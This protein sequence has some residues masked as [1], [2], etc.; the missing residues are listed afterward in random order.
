M[1]LKIVLGLIAV[2]FLISFL[3]SFPAMLLWN[4]CLVPA[5]PALAEVGWLQMWGI[6]ILAGLMFKTNISASGKS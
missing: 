5:I 4:Y 2:A 6:S 1:N 3:V